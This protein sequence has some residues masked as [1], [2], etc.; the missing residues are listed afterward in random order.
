M[1]PKLLATF[2]LGLLLAVGWSNLAVAQPVDEASRASARALGREGMDAYRANNFPLASSKLERA[3]RVVKAPAL[4][5]WSAR[6]FEKN[7]KLVEAA[8]RY[9]EATRL[10]VTTGDQAT[11]EQ[12]RID[13]AK[14][15]EAL[16][17]R[18]ANL[19]IEVGGD[20]KEVLIDGAA[21]PVDLLGVPRPVNPGSHTVVAKRDRVEKTEQVS[22]KEGERQVLK[23]ELPP[24][25][26]GSGALRGSKGKTQG[27]SSKAGHAPG[28]TQRIAGWSALAVG[29]VGLAVGGVAGVL[30]ITKHNSSDI[31]AQCVGNR[32]PT[33]LQG[34]VDSFNMLRNV[35]TVG[36]IVGAVGVGAGVTLLLTS[37]KQPSQTASL[38]PWI[39]LGSVGVSGGF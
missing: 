28:R 38:T 32:C 29:G 7:G 14:E 8:E 25:P 12:A 35:S 15:R 10:P 39:G 30:V 27:D 36:F 4:A 34:N 24:D 19:M 22:L 21:V 11:Q 6:A 26:H 23:L 20:V 9:L 3:Y 5:L 31:E 18:I 37:P 13:A 33:S 2:T 16:L 17:P 1:Q